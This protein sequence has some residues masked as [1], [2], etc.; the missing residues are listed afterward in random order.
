MTR[1]QVDHNAIKFGQITIVL[2]VVV[3]WLLNLPWLVWLLAGA[4]ALNVAWPAQGP[5]RLAYRSVILPLRIVRPHL[6]VDDP[7]PHRFAQGMGAG[8]LVAAG[9]A[10]SAGAGILGWVLAGLVALL[11]AVNVLWNFCAGC[12]IFLQ[13]RRYGVVRGEVAG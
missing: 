1:P 11:A 10:L 7:A 2:V 8:V 9:A 4:L 12:F 3:A 13:L 5:I 6:V